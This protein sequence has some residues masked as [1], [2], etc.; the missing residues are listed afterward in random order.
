MTT[1]APVGPPKVPFT[2]QD[3]ES[4]LL[5][6]RRHWAFITWQLVKVGFIA[7]VPIGVLL[8]VAAL[9]YGLDG[10]PGLI[11]WGICAIWFV[12]WAVRAY[13]TW[14]RYNN[15]IWVITNQRLIDSTR[16]HWF[17]HRMASA[18]L[19]DVEDMSIHKEG[20]FATMF[21]YGDVNVQTA[22]AQSKFVLSG[23][24]RTTEVMTL[25]DHQRDVAKRRLRGVT[26]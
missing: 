14:Y 8:A 5:L 13:F 22:G 24:P 6:A 19:D 23:I 18:D 11:T 10:T 2:L 4:I 16:N 12:F 15:D 17:H 21:K 1:I 20:L 9:T 7:L 26:D 3:A 25:V